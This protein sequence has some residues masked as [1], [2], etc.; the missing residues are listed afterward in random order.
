MATK[1]ANAL[2][3]IYIYIYTTCIVHSV[4]FYMY[5]Y[6]YIIYIYIYPRGP[7]FSDGV[8]GWDGVGK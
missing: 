5:I 7:N 2:H 8:G 4:L 3:N 1:E 6:I